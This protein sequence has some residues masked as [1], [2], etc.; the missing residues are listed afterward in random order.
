MP[1]VATTKTATK[2]EM[3]TALID[4]ADGDDD[5]GDESSNVRSNRTVKKSRTIFAFV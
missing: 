3:Q 5:N 2:M 1:L 4:G